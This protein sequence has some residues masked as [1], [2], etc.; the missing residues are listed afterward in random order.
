MRSDKIE[1]KTALIS[2]LTIALLSGLLYFSFNGR[3]LAEATLVQIV[4]NNQ[5]GGSSIST[6]IGATTAGNLIVVCLSTASNL[7]TSITDNRSNT[8]TLATRG[9][10][11]AGSEVSIYYSYNTTG[12]VTS[13]VGTFAGWANPSRIIVAEYSGIAATNPLDKVSNYNN[14]WNGGASWTS[15]ATVSTTQADELLVG[16]AGDAYGTS[17]TFGAGTDYTA[18]RT[19]ASLF[20][21]DRIVASTGTY[22]A[23]GSHNLASGYAIVAAVA[24]FK[25]GGTPVDNPPNIS[26]VASSTTDTAATITWTTDEAATSQVEYGLTTSY[27]QRSTKLLK[28]NYG[29]MRKVISKSAHKMKRVSHHHTQS[30]K[31]QDQI[32][33]NVLLWGC[34]SKMHWWRRGK[35]NLNRRRSKMLPELVSKLRVGRTE[36]SFF[37][38]NRSQCA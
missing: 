26:S 20:F 38:Y 3:T 9:T 8:Y 10:Y 24:T 11:G 28:R 23:T 34:I 5:G 14:G 22:A 13:V 6:S 25:I 32:T 33:I 31:S 35:V 7:S 16:C 4:G 12:G 17:A 36:F 15:Q 29:L 21:E 30:S 37:W 27:S 19:E 1:N 2:L 18:R